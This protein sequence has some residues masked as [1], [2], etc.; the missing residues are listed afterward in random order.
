M[1]LI[2]G[3]AVDEVHADGPSRNGRRDGHPDG[4]RE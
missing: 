2:E 3:Y 1:R 4:H